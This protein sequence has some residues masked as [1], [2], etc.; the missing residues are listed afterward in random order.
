MQKLGYKEGSGL[1][2]MG[3]GISQAL[4]VER[5]GKNQGLIVNNDERE[6][7]RENSGFHL[8]KSLTI[9]K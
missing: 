5:T 6:S 4:K 7:F 3:Q 8:L 2:R 1:G 9:T